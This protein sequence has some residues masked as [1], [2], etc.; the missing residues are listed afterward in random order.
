VKETPLRYKIDLALDGTTWTATIH[1]LPDKWGRG[2]CKE[3]AIG[4]LVR[5]WPHLFGISIEVKSLSFEI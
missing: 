4:D 5:N 2:E 3:Q 1:E